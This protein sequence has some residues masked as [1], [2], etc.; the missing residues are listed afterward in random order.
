MIPVPTSVRVWLAV[1]RTDMNGLAVQVQEVL[2][3]RM[4]AIFLSSWAL[5]RFGQ[6]S[7]A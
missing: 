4:R 2:K 5:M 6:D 7:L 1:G 3:I